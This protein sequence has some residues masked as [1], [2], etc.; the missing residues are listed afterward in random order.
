MLREAGRGFKRRVDEDY[1]TAVHAGVGKGKVGNS[2]IMAR[3]LG[4]V[5]ASAANGWGERFLRSY[6]AEGHL[7]FMDAEFVGL[8]YDAARLGQPPEETVMWCL[9][10][11]SSSEAMWLPLQVA[12][13]S[14]HAETTPDEFEWASGMAGCTTDTG[15]NDRASFRP[16]AAC[17]ERVA[18]WAESWLSKLYI[19]E[20]PGGKAYGNNGRLQALF[21]CHAFLG[22]RLSVC[23]SC[24]RS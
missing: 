1:V 6:A 23:G 5:G 22:S 19:V 15:G 9:E 16:Q 18:V 3:A 7:T 12:P 24:E 11:L 10:K 20:M 8:T 4:D 21:A 17:L 2:S 14:A 13:R